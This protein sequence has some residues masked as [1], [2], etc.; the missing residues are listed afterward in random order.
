MA[1]T[2]ALGLDGASAMMPALSSADRAMGS[3]RGDGFD[4]TMRDALAAVPR[5]DEHRDR[6]RTRGGKAASGDGKSVPREPAQ[7]AARAADRAHS[8]SGRDKLAGADVSD[9][10]ADAA[11]TDEEGSDSSDPATSDGAPTNH[12]VR[13]GGALPPPDLA[14]DATIVAA[15]LA[16]AESGLGS[17]GLAGGD[18]MGAASS[19]DVTSTLADVG[20][21]TAMTAAIPDVAHAA[22]DTAA[23]TAVNTLVNSL[24][25]A[26]PAGDLTAGADSLQ[27]GV[28]PVAA[29][30]AVA[31]TVDAGLEPGVPPELARPALPRQGLVTDVSGGAGSSSSSTDANAHGSRGY[32]T[33]A[34]DGTALSGSDAGTAIAELDT[35]AG[36]DSAALDALTSDAVND[37]RAAR[38]ERTDAAETSRADSSAAAVSEARPAALARTSM[39][40]DLLGRLQTDAMPDQLSQR[41][42][43]M[44]QAG[45]HLARLQVHPAALGPIDIALDQRDG[46]IAVS[47]TAQHPATRELLEIHLPRMREQLGQDGTLVERFDILGGDR[48]GDRGGAGD[49]TGG[50][51]RSDRGGQN[52]ADELAD[53]G[54]AIRL[55]LRAAALFEA[56]A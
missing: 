1:S 25:D 22:V 52:G 20:V 36:A 9:A 27:S 49:R 7:V 47:M 11:G 48:G 28:T 53:A 43:W 40:G 41:M 32:D 14:G 21:G 33:T 44:Q 30:P 5:A 54:P 46:A 51:G 10:G 55:P 29:A 12:L 24:V 45:V 19:L 3:A 31:A 35:A 8:S 18:A 13:D 42:L 38:H 4:A 34:V 39:L 26:V 50:D 6:H 37:A 23:Q 2:I 16:R 15:R 56:Y 17:S